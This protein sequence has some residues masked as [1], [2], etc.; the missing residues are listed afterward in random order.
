M[1][2]PSIIPIFPLARALLLPG[3]TLPLVIFESRYLAMVNEALAG[4]QMIGMIQ[5]KKDSKASGLY[6]IGCLG[7]ITTV[8]EIEDGRMLIALSGVSRFLLVRELKTDQPFRQIEASYGKF[9]GDM[10]PEHNEEK[11]DRAGLLSV[12]KRYLKKNCLK[13]DWQAIHQASS[14]SLV[15]AISILS[16]Y[17]VVEKQALLEAKDSPERCSLL[18]AL[19]E[20]ALAQDIQDVDDQA[21]P[22][23]Q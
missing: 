15:T 6:A 3:G 20:M 16:S 14:A 8:N 18:I 22:T 4:N 9:R 7:R 19:T 5:P 11:I 10:E 12:L 23:I 1:D 21:K 2:L 13:A 17:G